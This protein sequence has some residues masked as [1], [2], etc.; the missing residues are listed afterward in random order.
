M[1]R[2]NWRQSPRAR[3]PL[4]LPALRPWC[5]RLCPATPPA[6]ANSYAGRKDLRALE[7]VRARNAR[8]G[9]MRWRLR[10]YSRLAG[11]SRARLRAWS[12]IIRCLPRRYSCGVDDL[13]PHPSFNCL[14]QFA[15]AAFEEM[16]SG[17]N[18]DQLLRLRRR[19]HQRFQFCAW[20]ELIASAANEKLGLRAIAQEVIGI[21]ARLFAAAGD[22]DY[23]GSHSDQRFHPWV[24][25]GRAQADRR[26]KGKACEDKRETKFSVQPIE[27]SAEVLDFAVS[28]IMLTLAQ[29]G[30]AKIKTQHRKAKTVQGFHGMEDDF[31]VQGSTEQRMRM[32]DD[33]SISRVWSS[34]VEQRFQSSHGTIEK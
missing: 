16:I 24:R 14:P 30:A 33:R 23:R 11:K 28:V 15:Q 21:N 7:A 10:P 4:G 12:E 25:A 27:R 1:A 5:V 34:G 20:P 19:G 13:I 29:A 17:F 26:A 22:R 2:L 8:A 31:I 18:N 32:A 9:Q 6:R 3:R